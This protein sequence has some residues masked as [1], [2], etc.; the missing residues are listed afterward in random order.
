MKTSFKKRKFLREIK[1]LFPLINKEL[2]FHDRKK[3][4]IIQKEMV[5]DIQTLSRI[6]FRIEQEF[7]VCSPQQLC[8]IHNHIEKIYEFCQKYE[9]QTE[10]ENIE[11]TDT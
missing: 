1:K 5:E 8:S 10:E 7:C 9:I 4:R 11:R 2:N 3:L 6:A